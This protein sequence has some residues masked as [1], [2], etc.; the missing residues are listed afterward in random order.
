M[1]IR[2]KKNKKDKVVAYLDGKESSI[3]E[4]DTELMKWIKKFLPVEDK[5]EKK[6][7]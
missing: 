3:P 1:Q 6:R 5:P 7:A 4:T 2:K